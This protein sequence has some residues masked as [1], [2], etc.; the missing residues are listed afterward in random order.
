MFESPLAKTG[1]RATESPRTPRDARGLDLLRTSPALCA[2]NSR[3]HP[4]ATRIPRHGE[5]LVEP[6]LHV[7]LRRGRFTSFLDRSGKYL[8]YNELTSLSTTHLST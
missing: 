3:G 2:T 8:L 4:P 6:A 5:G 7:P 1:L